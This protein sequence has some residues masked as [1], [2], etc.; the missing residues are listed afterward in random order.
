LRRCRARERVRR[1]RVREV[2]AD[3]L[4]ADAQRAQRGSSSERTSSCAVARDTKT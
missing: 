4:H 1:R 2:V 3:H